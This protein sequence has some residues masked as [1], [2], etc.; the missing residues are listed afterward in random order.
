MFEDT[1]RLVESCIDGYNVCLFAYGQTGSGKTF[2]MTGSPDM[3]GMCASLCAS[4]R[5]D[6]LVSMIRLFAD[7]SVLSALHILDILL[8]YFSKYFCLFSVFPCNIQCFS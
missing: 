2:T 1:K 3:P 7:F 6:V 5:A 4:L 8:F